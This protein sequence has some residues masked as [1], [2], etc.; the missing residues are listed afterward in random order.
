MVWF[1]F[2]AKKPN[3]IEIESGP[4]L[5]KKPWVFYSR[6]ISILSNHYGNLSLRYNLLILFFLSTSI[7]F[8]YSLLTIFFLLCPLKIWC[9]YREGLNIVKSLWSLVFDVHI[10]D[11][12]LLIYNAFHFIILCKLAENLWLYTQA[13]RYSI[14]ELHHHRRICTCHRSTPPYR[15]RS[16]CMFV[17]PRKQKVKVPLIYTLG[18]SELCSQLCMLIH[19]TEMTPEIEIIC[20]VLKIM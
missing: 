2:K 13:N 6:N 18:V 9:E 5:S 3:R 10:I 19:M 14:K 17:E 1:G 4:L 16:F 8:H 20:A 12:V 15:L 11:I 7:S